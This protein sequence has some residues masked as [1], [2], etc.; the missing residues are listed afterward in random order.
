MKKIF[1]LVL[2]VVLVVCVAVP[3][4]AKDG[5]NTSVKSSLPALAQKYENVR[6]HE[7]DHLQEL[8]EEKQQA[9]KDAEKALQ[10]VDTKGLGL[11]YFLYTE[12]L[13][14]ENSVSLDFKPIPHNEILFM[15]YIDGMWVTLEHSI[16]DDR[17][18]TIPE[19]VDAPFAIFV[20]PLPSPGAKWTNLI[21]VL[22]DESYLLVQLHTLEEVV[23]LS[24]E[25]QARMAEAKEL[26]KDACPAGFAVK[27]FFEMEI[28]GTE[29]AV[30]VDF[31]PI[32]HNEI[33]FKQFVNGAWV[34]LE[35]STDS[36][37]IIT[38][39]GL[40]DGPVATFIK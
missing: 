38:V 18:I 25:I 6:L 3:A 23:T 24:E 2:A 26:L 20:D 40:L 14:G 7:R 39:F 34:E 37:G 4:A 13:S 27:Y 30:D 17:I 29:G 22:T 36:N 28:L 16:G 12:I 1:A 15:Q 8:S 5:L 19:D 31:E 21:P 33:V 9:M 32:A 35:S 11:K 10:D